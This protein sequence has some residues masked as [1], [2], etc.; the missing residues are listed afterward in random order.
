MKD[1]PLSWMKR[2]AEYMKSYEINENANGFK[3]AIAES[4]K[5]FF[6]GSGISDSLN[7]RL[8]MNRSSPISLEK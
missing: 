7:R 8:K 5:V 1:L 3:T 6:S 2:D 4:S